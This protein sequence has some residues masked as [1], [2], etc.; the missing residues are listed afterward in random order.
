MGGSVCAG[1]WDWQALREA[2]LRQTRAILGDGAAAEDAAQE[3]LLRAWCKR[4]RCR[5]VEDPRG[6]VAAIARREALRLVTRR[7]EFVL[8][9]GDEPTGDSLEESALRRLAIQEKVRGLS[10]IERQIVVRRFWEGM[11]CR[12]TADA[13][14]MPEAT[15]RVKLH[16]LRSRTKQLGETWV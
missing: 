12:E 9:D 16:R 15:V 11:T 10:E 14:G 1:R 4:S 5:A 13:L 7:Q 8:A 2:C 3:A 6:W